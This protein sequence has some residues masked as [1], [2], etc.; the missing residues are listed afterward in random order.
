MN[1][2]NRKT[3]LLQELGDLTKKLITIFKESK[4][5]NYDQIFYQRIQLIKE[6][7]QIDNE[8]E[9]KNHPLA[10]QWLDQLQKI[11]RLDQEFE[12]LVDFRKQ[13]MERSIA[14]EKLNQGVLPFQ[15]LLSQQLKQIKNV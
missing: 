8:I 15:S 3:A 1:A 14:T 10:E 4:P 12:D 7:G 2:A 5:E 11:A 9:L 13:M 6:L